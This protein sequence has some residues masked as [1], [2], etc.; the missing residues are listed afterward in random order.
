MATKKELIRLQMTCDLPTIKFNI[1]LKVTHSKAIK[2][3]KAHKR[4]IN[5][6]TGELGGCHEKVLTVTTTL[7]K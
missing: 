3:M 1:D 2:I 6:I 7:I 4:M 5:N